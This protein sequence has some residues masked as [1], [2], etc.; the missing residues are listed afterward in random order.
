[1]A[2]EL[3]LALQRI[4]KLKS[5]KKQLQLKNKQLEKIIQEAE[6][7]SRLKNEFIAN[8]SHEM[9]TPLNAIVGFSEMLN[10]G[11]VGPTSPKYNEFLND[12][13]DS[14]MHLVMFINDVLDLAKIEANKIEFHPEKTNLVQLS[15]SVKK[16][17]YKN[18]VDKNITFKINIDP[19]LDEIIIDPIKLKQ[20]FYNYISNAL[21]FTPKNGRVTVTISQFRKKNFRLEIKD[22]GVGIR[23]ED[24]KKLFVKFQQLDVSSKKKYQGTGLGLALT[25]QIV[26]AQGGQVGVKSVPGKG[27]TFFAILPCFPYHKAWVKD[28]TKEKISTKVPTI[29]VIEQESQDRTL[30]VNTL[31]QT[32]YRVITSAN[33]RDALKQNLHGH[34]DAII[35]DLFQPNLDGWELMRT[36]RF[37]KTTHE[38]PPTVIKVILES[39]LG[40]GYKIRDFIVKPV[41]PKKLL[42]ALERVEIQA[43]KNKTILIIDDDQKA[44]LLADKVLTKA[45]FQIITRNDKIS[46]LLAL[47]QEC[48][49]VVIFDP[50]MSGMDGLEFLRYYRQT[51]RGIL[52]PMII[53]SARK[54]NAEEQMHFNA[55]IQRVVLQSE[56]SKKKKLGELAKYLPQIKL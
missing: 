18:I 48:P 40:I 21:K 47:E 3:K 50:F 56:E 46:A 38:I 55:S 36:L 15:E 1:M 52:T 19:A 14:A 53:W 5:A 12:I 39:P 26:E 34:F 33:L 9:R 37:K 29:L 54:L 8:I 10:K 35:L 4:E 6:E 32:G 13:T 16:I 22:S 49:D 30:M 17:F 23:Q 28:K 2:T 11:I 20:V 7:S 31:I 42:T 51:E 27:S 45:G 41:T 24:L 25:K 43:H 44:L